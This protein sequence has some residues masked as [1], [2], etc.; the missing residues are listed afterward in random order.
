MT[1]SPAE[2]PLLT[3]GPPKPLTP[4]PVPEILRI[5][6]LS[7]PPDTVF[8]QTQVMVTRAPQITTTVRGKA[9]HV[10]KRQQ[11]VLGGWM[12]FA[13]GLVSR[14]YLRITWGVF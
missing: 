14:Y 8:L 10:Q 1:Q 3:P 7:H 11:A 2:R 13:R 12:T 6:G 5:P 9:V 4:C